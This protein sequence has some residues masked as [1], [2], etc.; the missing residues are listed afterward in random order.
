MPQFLTVAE[1]AKLTGKSASSIRRIIHPITKDDTHPDRAQIQPSADEARERRLRAETFAWRVSEELLRKAV[2]VEQPTTKD[3]AP[4]SARPAGNAEGELLAMLRHELEIKN[5]QITQQAEIIAKQMH[6]IDGLGERLRESSFLLGS[7]Q[8]QLA[9]PNTR[10]TTAPEPVKPK[11]TS[12]GS[13]GG[14]GE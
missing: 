8:K 14:E 5:G 1:A 3:D 12:A 7:L 10:E 2:R 13:P 6:T 4:A 9:L 11:R